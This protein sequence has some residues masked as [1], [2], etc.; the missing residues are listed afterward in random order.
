MLLPKERHAD[1]CTHSLR[2]G[3]RQ[4]YI[5][6]RSIEACGLAVITDGHGADLLSSMPR[7]VIFYEYEFYLTDAENDNLLCKIMYNYKLIYFYQ[8]G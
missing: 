4:K 8:C 1:N 3:I 7:N 5:T 6:V 2:V